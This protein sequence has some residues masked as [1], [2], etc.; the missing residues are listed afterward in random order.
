MHM[1]EYLKVK[2]MT[3][4][5]YCDYLQSKYGIGKRDYYHRSS[6]FIDM[7]RWDDGLSTHFK[8]PNLVCATDLGDENVLVCSKE[9]IVYCDKVE[10]IFIDWLHIIHK[11]NEGIE[12]TELQELFSELFY[13]IRTL[14]DLYYD[15][16]TEHTKNELEYKLVLTDK[17]VFIGLLTQYIKSSKCAGLIINVDTIIRSIYVNKDNIDCIND[18]RKLLEVYGENTYLEIESVEL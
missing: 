7:F 13:C 1:D 15:C 12:N 17:D 2:D 9:N 8:E 18:T 11:R 16:F 6:R 4:L 10:E 3:Y 5:Q 14:S